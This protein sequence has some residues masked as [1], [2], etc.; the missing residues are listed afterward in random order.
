MFPPGYIDR[1]GELGAYDGPMLG[2]PSPVRIR[3]RSTDGD[4]Y[5]FGPGKADLLA[6]I[7]ET[8]SIVAAGRRMG[9]SYHKTRQ[10][11]DELNKT[12]IGPLVEGFKGGATGGGAQL[13]ELGKDVLARF[14]SMQKKAEAAV[15]QELDAFRKLLAP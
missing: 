9:M 8:G 13:T 12:F 14:L 4:L 15:T 7:Q 6:G 10:L 5:A 3:I 1:Q 11:V 2:N